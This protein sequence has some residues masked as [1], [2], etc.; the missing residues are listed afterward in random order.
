M[1]L[2]GG[3]DVRGTFPIWLLHIVNMHVLFFLSR[4]GTLFRMDEWDSTML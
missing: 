1:V 4:P 2:L 3:L